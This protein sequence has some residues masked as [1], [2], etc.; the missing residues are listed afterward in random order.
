MESGSRLLPQIFMYALL[1]AFKLQAGV[2]NIIQ[3]QYP[4]EKFQTN[5]RSLFH[6]V[7]YVLKNLVLL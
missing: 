3:A 6:C 5:S 1:A 7:C 2:L 4:L